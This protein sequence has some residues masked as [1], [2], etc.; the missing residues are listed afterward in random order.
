MEGESGFYMGIFRSVGGNGLKGMA[1]LPGYTSLSIFE[2]STI[3][4]EL[5][6]N[7]SLQHSP[8]CGAG[9]PDQNYPY[10]GGSVRV[11]EYDFLNEHA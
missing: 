11:W 7:L 4:H 8:G 1:V 10:E 3:A 5:G 6:H 9:T 2:G